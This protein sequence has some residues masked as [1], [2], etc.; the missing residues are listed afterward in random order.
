MADLTRATADTPPGRA[1]IVDVA[2]AAQVSRQTVSNALNRPDKV[3]AP[4]LE[5]V[6]REIDR[7]GF[8][9]HITAQQL[10]R[11]KAAAYGFEVNP[12][13]HGRLGHILDEFLVQLTVAAPAHGSHLMTF[14]PDPEDVIE[15]YRQTLATGLVD[16]FVLAD[17]RH[18]DPRPQWLLDHHVPFVAFGRVWDLPELRQWVDVDG[19]AGVREAVAHLVAAG[20]DR[21]GFL[22]WP[23]GSPVGDDRR[24]G[25]LAGLADAGRTAS[26][27]LEA[28][29]SVQDLDQATAAAE[30]LLR[31]LGPGSA[32][33]CASDML[34]LGAVRAVR[35][36]GL[37]LGAD[38]G[39]VGFDDTDVAD[40][41]SVTSIRQPIAEAARTAWQMLTSPESPRPVLLAPA[42]TVRSSTTRTPTSSAT[43]PR[44]TPITEEQP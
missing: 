28:E 34:A 40:A 17:T 18:G 36:T 10:R 33:V 14:A 35:N 27:Q 7:L 37:A 20:Y 39:V 12:S 2:R 15:G 44:D 3:A 6:L 41:L 38:I 4:T 8:T 5:R 30:R 11:R 29:E 1:T 32:V 24:H 26:G 42:L 25:W 9:P 23:A 21:I 19:G 16:G 43:R 13:G 22:G 31:R